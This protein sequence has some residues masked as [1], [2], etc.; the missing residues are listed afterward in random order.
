MDKRKRRLCV[1]R[2][3]STRGRARRKQWPFGLEDWEATDLRSGAGRVR[4][5]SASPHF[6]KSPS[7]HFVER[8][9]RY[10][11]LRSADGRAQKKHGEPIPQE[12]SKTSAAQSARYALSR[13]F[14]TQRRLRS[15]CVIPVLQRVLIRS[16][17]RRA[18]A[19]G[20][21]H[22]CPMLPHLTRGCWADAKRRFAFR[23][24]FEIVAD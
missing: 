7:L 5:A 22:G 19:S 16:I 3:T 9:S 4:R 15:R 21:F 8:E 1:P 24:W 12:L 13:V 20:R 11:C 2:E 18:S 14:L 17:S 6:V 23:N 10:G